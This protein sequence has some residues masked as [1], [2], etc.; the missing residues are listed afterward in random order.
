MITLP[1]KCLGQKKMCWTFIGWLQ[2]L[3]KADDKSELH[4][5]LIFQSL[6]NSINL[7]QKCMKYMW[8]KEHKI[9][10]IQTRKQHD[11]ACNRQEYFWLK[12]QCIRKK[13]L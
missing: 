12:H 5:T 3:L 8:H 13:A 11:H 2:S 10:Q 9:Q 1:Q 4:L 6:I 7:Q